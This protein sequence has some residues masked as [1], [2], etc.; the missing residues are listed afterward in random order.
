MTAA[1]TVVFKVS[2]EKEFNVCNGKEREKREELMYATCKGKERKE[3]KLMYAN[4]T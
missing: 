3:K 2:K 4:A 1:G